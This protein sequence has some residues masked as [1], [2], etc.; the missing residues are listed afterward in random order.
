MGLDLTP[1]TDYKSDVLP[2]APSHPSTTLG[3]NKN[4][5]VVK[6]RP[7]YT[8]SCLRPKIK[9]GLN[10]WSSYPAFFNVEAY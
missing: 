3:P 8:E 1:D 4:K 7:K 6:V 5:L 9:G 10:S 2:T